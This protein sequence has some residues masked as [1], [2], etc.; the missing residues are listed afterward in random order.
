M[1]WSSVAKNSGQAM[2][3]IVGVTNAFLVCSSAV[4]QQYVVREGHV[5]SVIVA[6]KDDGGFSSLAARDSRNISVS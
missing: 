4:A 1:G 6:Q 2:K 3:V 5:H